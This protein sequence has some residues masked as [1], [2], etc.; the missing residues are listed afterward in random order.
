MYVLFDSPIHL[1]RSL[2]EHSINIGVWGSPNYV[3]RGEFVA[4]ITAITNDPPPNFDV[5]VHNLQNTA[6]FVYGHLYTSFYLFLQ[7]EA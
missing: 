1:N 6:I 2:Q 4:Q 7:K 5:G 3:L